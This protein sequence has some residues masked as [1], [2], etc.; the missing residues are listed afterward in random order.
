M[1][2]IIAQMCDQKAFIQTILAY[3]NLI[4]STVFVYTLMFV[5][6]LLSTRQVNKCK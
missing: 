5:V 1:V 3:L 2:L 6:M 4:S